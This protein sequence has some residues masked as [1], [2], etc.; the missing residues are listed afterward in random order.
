MKNK[1][2]DGIKKITA[3]MPGDSQIVVALVLIAVAIG[4]CI[5]FRNQIYKIM[6]NLFDRISLQND[7]LIDSLLQQLQHLQQGVETNIVINQNK[8]ILAH[9]FF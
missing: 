1:I 6:S 4:L 7:K 9:G 3:K 8:T 5:I 2:K